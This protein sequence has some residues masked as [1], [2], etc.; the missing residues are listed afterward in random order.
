MSMPA[1][2]ATVLFDPRGRMGRSEFL[3]SAS[4]V[5]ALEAARAMLEPSAPA[6]VLVFL[7]TVA[8]WM[9]MVALVKRLHD[10][11]RSGWLALAGAAA[12][13]IWSAVLGIVAVAV[14]GTT[15][16]DI[17]SVVLAALV[18]LIAMPAIG[19]ALWLHLAP[20][21]PDANRFAAAARETRASP[22]RNSAV[23]GA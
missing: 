23:A 12:L 2:L 13:C 14:L 6:T 22:A 9:G 17:G 10:L 8:L 7:K 21:D 11:G 4:A 19:A 3:I 20:G 16:L 15:A 5:L 1:R 18:G